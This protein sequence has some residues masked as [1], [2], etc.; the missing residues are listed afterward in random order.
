[1][2]GTLMERRHF[3][4]PLRSI[5]SDDVSDWFVGVDRMLEDMAGRWDRA[6]EHFNEYPMSHVEKTSD[7]HYRVLVKVPG[8]DKADLQVQR[9]DDELVVRGKHE[10]KDQEDKVERT[11]SFEQ[12]FFL[13]PDITV[14][15][16]K[17]DG[18]ELTVDVAFPEPKAPEVQEITLT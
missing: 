8:Y 4:T 11:M 10:V 3:L 14:E 15:A 9:I 7:G 5:F 13:A 17:F 16:A 2:T 12:H 18:G 1:M 6:F